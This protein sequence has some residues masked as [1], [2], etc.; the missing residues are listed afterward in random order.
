MENKFE[1]MQTLLV[2][3]SEFGDDRSF[4]FNPMKSGMLV[5][6]QPTR[7]QSPHLDLTIQGLSIPIVESYKYLGIE[8]SAAD[9][10]LL[11][12]WEKLSEKADKA[13]QRLNARTLWSFQRFEVSKI[14]WKATAT[15][16]LIYCNAKIAMP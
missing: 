7:G 8:L 9:D 1:D 15:P 13:I 12:H 11:A 10:Y 14:L 6:S 2:I 4:E 3:I 16:Q 5:F